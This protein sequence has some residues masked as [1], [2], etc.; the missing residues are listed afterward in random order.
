LYQGYI[1]LKRG[2][3]ITHDDTEQIRDLRTGSWARVRGTAQQAT[4]DP[5]Q[6]DITGTE[7]VVVVTEISYRT[8]MGGG[9]GDLGAEGEMSGSSVESGE[10]KSWR[11]DHR[12]FDVVPFDRTDQTET[13]RVDPTLTQRTTKRRRHS[14]VGRTGICRWF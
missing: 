13:T 4:E 12:Q 6:A 2:G 7:G 8:G 3:S 9:A 11:P 14:T 1:K 5:V 10:A